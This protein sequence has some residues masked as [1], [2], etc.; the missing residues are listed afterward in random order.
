MGNRSTKQD[1]LKCSQH[2]TGIYVRLFISFTV[3]GS[4]WIL[5]IMA[6]SF[7]GLP[8]TVQCFFE[9]AVANSKLK[10]VNVCLFL[11]GC[12]KLKNKSI[13]ESMLNKF[14]PVCVSNNV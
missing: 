2:F 4:K 6:F 11:N 13:N 14:S 8:E 10:S 9:M 1:Q 12:G 5:I 7:A 3:F